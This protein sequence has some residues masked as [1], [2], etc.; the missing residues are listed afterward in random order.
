M[1]AAAFIRLV[2]HLVIDVV[3]RIQFADDLVRDGDLQSE[4]ASSFQP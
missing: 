3:E 2:A 1:H 4:S